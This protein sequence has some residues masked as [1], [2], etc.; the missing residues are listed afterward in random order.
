MLIKKDRADYEYDGRLDPE[1]LKQVEKETNTFL[2]ERHTVTII[3][4]NKGIRTW[5][6]GPVEMHS[7]GTR[8]R[9]NSEIGLIKLRRKNPRKGEEQIETSLKE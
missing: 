1:T 5:R 6:C 7:A 8:V 2:L 9:N 3:V 4:D